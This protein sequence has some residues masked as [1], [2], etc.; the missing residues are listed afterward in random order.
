M[1]FYSILRAEYKLVYSEMIRRRSA[2]IAM[3]LYPLSLIHI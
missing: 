3:I 1:S 2:L